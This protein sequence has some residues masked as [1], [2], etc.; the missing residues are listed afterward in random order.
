MNL[1]RGRR[2]WFG[3]V[4][5]VFLLFFA[6]A[7]PAPKPIGTE[8]PAEYDL[9]AEG[10]QMDL[11][12]FDR[13]LRN[14]K[15]GKL[16]KQDRNASRCRKCVEVEIQSIGLT[17]DIDETRAPAKARVVARIQNNHNSDTAAMYGIQPKAKADYY[18]WVDGAA[19]GT[20][21]WT[22]VE[23]QKEPGGKARVHHGP[24][25]SF[26]RC[27][28]NQS[29]KV[30][31]A[32]FMSCAR[33]HPPAVKKSSLATDAW[34]GLMRSSL[35]KLVQAMDTSAMPEDPAWLRCAN[36]CCTAVYAM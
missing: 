6:L 15:Y 8:T 35:L 12:D 20:A 32:N 29:D 21:R 30:S 24:T 26:G 28:Y 17:T 23:L 3:S 7:C 18:L 33:A 36:G 1:I 10:S 31:E 2:A 19:N 13:F 34:L 22:V 5:V 9:P 25:G 16:N 4:S 27:A 14:Y 11:S